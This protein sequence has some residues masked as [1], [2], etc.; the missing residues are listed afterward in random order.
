MSPF[1][2]PIAFTFLILVTP[3]MIFAQDSSPANASPAAYPVSPDGL[4]FLI[5]DVF[6]AMKSKDDQKV[7]SYFSSMTFPE[8]TAW[9]TKNLWAHRRRSHGRK[10][11]RSPARHAGEPQ[12]NL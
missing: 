11:R 5:R 2:R 9:F 3:F 7:S 8:H 10:V 12:K 1:L 4:K 6:T